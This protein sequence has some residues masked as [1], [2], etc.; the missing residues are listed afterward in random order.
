[1]NEKRAVLALVLFVCCVMAVFGAM[2]QSGP[3]Q[4]PA[5]Y[6][7]TV[8]VNGVNPPAGTTVQAKIEGVIYKEVTV[9]VNEADMVYS[10]KFKDGSTMILN[11]SGKP[12]KIKGTTIGD[13]EFKLF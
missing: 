13:A 8:K 6:Y 12:V 10:T 9:Q 4:R 2:T 3:P 11:Y 7:G 5:T 1:M